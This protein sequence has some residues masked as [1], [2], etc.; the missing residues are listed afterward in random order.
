MGPEKLDNGVY[1]IRSLYDLADMARSK[2][3]G[4][5]EKW[6]TKLARKL[7]HQ[8]EGTWWDT[9]AQQYADSLDDPGNEQNYQK[10]W[11]G[12]VPMEAEL[13]QGDAAT[14][15]VAS[16]DARDH[17]AGRARELVLQ[18]RPPRQPRPLPHRLRRRRRTARATSR[19]S[20]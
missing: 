11:I 8:F 17:R 1:Y 9:A 7:Q 12:Q 2:H 5:T 13:N 15:G 18:R 16:N 6:A 20:R 19:S 14:P 4:A 3:D 10:H